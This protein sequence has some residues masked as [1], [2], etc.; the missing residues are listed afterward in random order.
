MTRGFDRERMRRAFLQH[1][2]EPLAPNPPIAP[3]FPGTQK[4]DRTQ[5]M[6]MRIAGFVEMETNS[7][8]LKAGVASQFSG[9]TLHLYLPVD[10]EVIA[11]VATA[12][13]DLELDGAPVQT[14]SM[15]LHMLQLLRPAVAGFV[16]AIRRSYLMMRERETGWGGT[17]TWSSSAGPISSSLRRW[18]L[19]ATHAGSRSWPAAH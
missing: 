5:K 15:Q 3:V 19:G 11:K 9:A 7:A 10:R 14:A 6:G 16:T 18:P 1:V 2:V 12:V 17:S 4:L 8:A 13:A